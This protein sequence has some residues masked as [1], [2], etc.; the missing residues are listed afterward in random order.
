MKNLFPNSSI[1][2]TSDHRFSPLAYAGQQEDPILIQELEM[3]G[4]KKLYYF[5]PTSRRYGQGVVVNE[6]SL[7]GWTVGWRD[8][9]MKVVFASV[10]PVFHL[11]AH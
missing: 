2:V 7:G 8:V 11:E 5:P 6:V 1:T 9:E 4:L 3:E 10:S